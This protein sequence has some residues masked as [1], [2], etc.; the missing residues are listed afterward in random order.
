VAPRELS[1]DIFK[2]WS[3]E[4]LLEELHTCCNPNCLT[5]AEVERRYNGIKEEIRIYGDHIEGCPKR[6]CTC[7]FKAVWDA[8]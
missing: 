7:G 8:L 1:E 3:D 6:P 5:I 2:G 4:Q